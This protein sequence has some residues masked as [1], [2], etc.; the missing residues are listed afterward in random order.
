[1]SANELELLGKDDEGNLSVRHRKS[2]NVCTIVDTFAE[3]FPMWAG[4]VLITA[5]NGKWALTAAQVATGLATSVI[6]SP[7]EA[8]IEGTVATE[9]PD[10]RTG[11][12]IQIYNRNR[13]ELKG[14]MILRIGQ[15]IMTCPTA[16][17]FDGMPQAKR[18]LRVGRS[19]RYFGDGFQ[20]KAMVGDRKVWKIPVMEGYFVVEDSFG[21][22]EAVAGGNLLIMA[23]DRPTG[24]E[25][26]ERA[27][28]AIKAEASDIVMPF[29]GGVCRSGSKAGSLK[30]KLK[31]S[32]NHSFCPQ[33]RALVSDSQV[34]SGVECVYEIVVNGLTLDAVKRAMSA[35]IR[36]AVGV[37]G[38]VRISAGNYGGKLGPYK[39]VLKD[40][41]N[42]V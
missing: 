23:K 19:L 13:F 39:A 30:Y 35:G 10:G 1:M 6:L 11:V 20:K 27:V 12:L 28:N 16:S 14:Q 21:A 33:L 29:P 32:T 17:A 41:L 18:R 7:A 22:A 8:G 36:T 38:V 4:R 5:D 37:F 15:C 26:A 2:G 24:L 42:L 25:A 3:M 9:T 31:A 40:L 34:P